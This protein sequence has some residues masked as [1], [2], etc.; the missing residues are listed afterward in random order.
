MLRIGKADGYSA[1]VRDCNYKTAANGVGHG[2]KHLDCIFVHSA[3]GFLSFNYAFSGQYKIINPDICLSFNKNGER[4]VSV[5]FE[6]KRGT[7]F[8]RKSNG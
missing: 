5:N 3:G 1:A 4:A 6:I 8:A 7:P 2:L